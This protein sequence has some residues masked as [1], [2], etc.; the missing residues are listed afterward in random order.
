MAETNR[1][2]DFVEPDRY[3]FGSI[4]FEESRIKCK[5][6][7]CNNNAPGA[8]T[9]A[10]V[11]AEF[12][13]AFGL[14][15]PSMCFRGLGANGWWESGFSTLDFQAQLDSVAGQVRSRSSQ[16]ESDQRLMSLSDERART[17]LAAWGTLTLLDKNIVDNKV[18]TAAKNEEVAHA[19]FSYNS[20]GVEV[21]REMDHYNDAICRKKPWSDEDL[22]AY[23][24]LAK[25]VLAT[26]LDREMSLTLEGQKE[27]EEV[28]KEFETVGAGAD[29]EKMPETAHQ[30]VARCVERHTGQNET[31]NE[32]FRLT[33]HRLIQGTG[34]FLGDPVRTAAAL[35]AEAYAGGHGRDG[36]SA[37]APA[38]A[39]AE[40]LSVPAYEAEATAIYELAGKVLDTLQ[41]KKRE[42]Y[43][44]RLIKSIRDLKRA[45]KDVCKVLKA[46]K[47]TKEQFTLDATEL[48][49]E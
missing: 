33:E 19:L 21:M 17:A 32:I 10:E 42:M 41:H 12:V 45:W 36:R 4:Y 23:K 13:D 8:C 39:A 24:G 49:R 1:S 38:P 30:L 43:R 31:K 11:L 15:L 47:I 28:S 20:A 46:A 26:T 7:L 35:A 5:Y 6:M 40:V 48:L 27:F 9:P 18:V 34:H 37:E 16:E 29:K 44:D 2:D 22:K 25:K 3:K 14:E